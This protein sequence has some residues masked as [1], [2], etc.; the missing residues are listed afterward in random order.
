MAVTRQE[1]IRLAAI[2][3]PD[4][5][6]VKSA[7]R[8]YLALTNLSI[9]QFATEVGRGHSTIQIWIAGHQRGSD[10][11]LRRKVWDYIERHPVDQADELRGG[12]SGQLFETENFRIIRRYVEAA[13]ELGEIC[14]IYGPPGTQKTFVLSHL[15]RERNRTLKNDAVYVYAS[16]EMRPIALLKRIA[17]GLGVFSAVKTIEGLLGAIIRELR[18]RARPPAVIVDEGQ[19]LSV[20]VLEILRELHDRTGSGLVLAGSHT[21]FENLLRGRQHLEQWLSRIDHK[22]PLPGLLEKEVR[23]IAA[24]ELGNGRPA[25]LSEKQLKAILDSCSVDDIFSRGEDGRITPRKY[26]SVRR[27]VKLLAQLKQGM[28]GRAV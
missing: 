22:D 19:H 8:K 21:L 5:E 13:C 12:Q 26:L 15:V 28:E 11:F 6:T 16:Q 25:Q 10:E 1:K 20:T 18:R 7:L 27:L 23:E 9:P 4:S 14:L 2:S 3:A 17:Q 24:R